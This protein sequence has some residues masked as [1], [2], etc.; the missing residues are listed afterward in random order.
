[1]HRKV[2]VDGT[3][4]RIKLSVGTKCVIQ[5]LKATKITWPDDL[6]GNDI[7]IMAIDGTHYAVEDPNHLIWSQDRECYSNKYNRAGINYKLG[8]SIAQNKLI[9]MNVFFKADKND[10]SIFTKNWLKN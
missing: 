10:E 7:W 8:I 5:C 1:M 4:R 3:L 9:W 6:G 2:A